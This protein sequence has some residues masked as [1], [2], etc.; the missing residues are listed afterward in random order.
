MITTEL[1]LRDSLLSEYSDTFKEAYGVRPNLGH[2]AH[3]T[4]EELQAEVDSICEIAHRVY[5]EEKAWEAQRE[6]AVRAQL[7]KLQSMAGSLEDAI[8][9]LHQAEDTD[10]NDS[11]LEYSLGVGYGFFRKLRAA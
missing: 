6:E 2:M 9:W 10:G 4:D 3:L 5:M 7:S 1:S 11:F 8:R